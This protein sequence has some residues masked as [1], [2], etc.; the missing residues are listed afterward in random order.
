MCGT[1]PEGNYKPRSH[2]MRIKP[3]DG[4]VSK[5]DRVLPLP[6]YKSNLILCFLSPSVLGAYIKYMILCLFSVN[7]L[8]N[9]RLFTYYAILLSVKVGLHLIS[10]MFLIKFSWYYA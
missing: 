2:I 7:E 1:S 4:K 5:N 9:K 10:G 8:V 6:P 3:V